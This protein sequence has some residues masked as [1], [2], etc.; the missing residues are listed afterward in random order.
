MQF[1]R[2][3][4]AA[5]LAF[6][7]GAMAQPYPSKPITLVVPFAPG[8]VTDSAA[9]VI[10]KGMSDRLGQ[11]VIVDNRAGAG[12]SVGSE[13]V[14][15]SRA[16]GYTLLFG[17]RVTQITN[18]LVN[19]TKVPTEAEFAAISTV[20]DVPGVMVINPNRPYKTVQELIAYAKAH[21]GGINFGTAGNGTASHLAGAVF[22]ELTGTKLTHVPYRGS[23]QVIQDLIGGQVDL[24][25]D[26]PSS[27]QSFIKN[28]RLRG[29]AALT[30]ARLQVLPELPTIG[31]AGVPGAENASW[32]AILA[33]GGTPVAVVER[34]ATAISKSLEDAEVRQKLID[35]GTVPLSVS[36]TELQKL[37]EQET[38]RYRGVVARSNIKA[39]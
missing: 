31:E 6:M 16:D 26:Y 36:G 13:F 38:V 9:R 39:D 28:G 22:M 3:A 21:P 14:S 34:L 8:G 7:G 11:P 23:A 25:F 20:C 1:A 37:I 2:F 30:P 27:T 18:P 10:A 24:A 12:G 15:K 33:P 4:A 19:K 17:S 32:Q 29:I 5:L 35:M